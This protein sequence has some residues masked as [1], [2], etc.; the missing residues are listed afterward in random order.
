MPDLPWLSLRVQDTCLTDGP[1]GQIV[2]V[3]QDG[4]VIGQ[5]GGVRAVTHTLRAGHL[6]TC[7]VE[8]DGTAEMHTYR[9]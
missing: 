1:E 2:K 8:F 5:L 4:K 6:G 9:A 7:S 3:L